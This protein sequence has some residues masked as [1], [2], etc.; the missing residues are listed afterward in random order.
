M[1]VRRR[2]GKMNQIVGSAPKNAATKRQD[3]MTQARGIKNSISKPSA[4]GYS[5]IRNSV[6]G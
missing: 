6:S 2:S 1:N 3:G 5:K 4:V